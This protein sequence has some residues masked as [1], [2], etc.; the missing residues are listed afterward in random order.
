MLL[1]VFLTLI[2]A[3]LQAQTLT[4]R[5]IIGLTKAGLGEDVLIALVEVHRSIFPV[6]PDTLKM[7]ND[8]GV[9]QKVI[10]AMVKSGRE[11]PAPVPAVEPLEDP[12][13]RIST[14][15][16]PVAPP[17]QVIV[18]D[19][20]REEP[21]VVEVPV[22]TPVYATTFWPTT[23]WPTTN[24]GR[25]DVDRRKVEPVFW[26]FGGKLRPDAWQPTLNDLPGKRFLLADGPQKK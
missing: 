26:G 20:P 17:P 2:P 4:T 9:P 12:E 14:R 16:L 10:V 3:S 23:F 25:H 21:R 13:P 5:D 1:A 22:A 7:L 24:R 15:S 6:D 19:H 11:N 18:V 8:A